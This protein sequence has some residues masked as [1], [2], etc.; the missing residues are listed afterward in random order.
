MKWLFRAALLLLVSIPTFAAPCGKIAISPFTGRFDCVGPEA[1]GGTAVAPYPF[2][3]TAQTTVT[4][5]AATHGQGIYASLNWCKDASNV[6]SSPGIVYGVT[7]NVTLTFSP[8]FTGSCV[9]GSGGGSVSGSGNPAG[10]GTELQYRNGANF[11]ALTSSSISGA[12]LTLGGNLTIGTTVFIDSSLYATFALACS[13]AVTAN[14]PLL[15]STSWTA[16]PTQTCA[17]NLT[18]QAGSAAMLQPASA[19]TLT[20]SGSINAQMV[21][22]FDTSLTGVISITSAIPF[23]YPTWFGASGSATTTTTVGAVT[24]PSTSM[25]VSSCTSFNAR[26]GVWI[27]GAGTAGAGHTATV[28]S[29]AA[30]AMTFTPATVTT[31]ITGKTVTH[32]D[33]RAINAT[34]AATSEIGSHVVLPAGYFRISSCDGNFASIALKQSTWLEGAGSGAV[35]SDGSTHYDVTT[36]DANHIAACRAIQ[37]PAN[38]HGIQVSNLQLIATPATPGVDSDTTGIYSGNGASSPV[39]ANVQVLGFANGIYLHNS[40]NAVLLNAE[41]HGSSIYDLIANGGSNL[42]IFGGMYSNGYNNIY[43]T[44]VA[45]AIVHAGLVDEGGINGILINASGDVIVDIPRMFLSHGGNGVRIQGDSTRITLRDMYILPFDPGRVPLNTISIAAG[46]T[47]IRLENIITDPNGG[48]DI[49][50]LGT[51]TFYDNVNGATQPTWIK[52]AI[53]SS[54][55]NLVVSGNGCIAS[56]TAK[57]AAL[58]QNIVLFQLPANGHVSQ[59]RLKTSTAYAGT[60]TLTAG[61]GTASSTDFYLVSATGYNLK[62]AVSATNLTTAAPIATGSDTASAVNVVVSL[63]STIDNISS[64]S[65][66]AVNVWVLKSVVP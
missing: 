57:A 22:V 4:V 65:A 35:L 18:F 16:I 45:G 10:V 63:T 14:A 58:T 17:A 53:T 28:V 7:G 21:Q 66:G 15:I 2:T 31:I 59:Y 46:S 52:C 1:G 36:I 34:I 29:C 62:T 20:L 8:A 55:T 23:Y 64:I 41:L 5:T 13:A 56:T 33:T 38:S 3:V 19:A 6:A 43:L 42:N 12:N 40:Q 39:I 44:G 47:N 50:D 48:G 9:I 60:T 25:T 24:A 49:S 37:G 30:G 54:S 51:N 11:G 26:Q 27:Q 32:D 61:L